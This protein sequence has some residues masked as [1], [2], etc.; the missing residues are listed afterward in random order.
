MVADML[1]VLHVVHVMQE[2]HADSDTDNAGSAS[3]DSGNDESAASTSDD[4]PGDPQELA[5]TLE[6]MQA[7]CV[8]DWDEI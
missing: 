7:A 5:D 3:S 4:E 8:D 6:E 2:A 1:D